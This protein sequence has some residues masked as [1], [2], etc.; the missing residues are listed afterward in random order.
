MAVYVHIR[1]QKQD[2]AYAEYSF[3][4]SEENSGLLRLDRLSGQTTLL[5]PAKNDIDNMAFM[6]ASRKLKQHWMRGELPDM[7]CWAS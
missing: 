7:T 4:A 6:R 1:K 3:G 2:E 5:V